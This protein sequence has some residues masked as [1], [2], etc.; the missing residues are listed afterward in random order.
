MQVVD[1]NAVID[2]LQ[3]GKQI[4][5]VDFRNGRVMQCDTLTM[6][7]IIT[8]IKDDRCMFFTENS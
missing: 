2:T 1:K 6:F 7:S 3:S 8:F 4:I 5:V